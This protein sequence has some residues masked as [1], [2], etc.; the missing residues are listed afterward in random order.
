MPSKTAGGVQSMFAEV[1]ATYEL[2]NHVLTLGLDVLW[3]R[4]AARIAARAGGADW[5]DMCTGTGE[6]AVYLSRLAPKGTKIYAIDFSGP[7]MEKARRKPGAAGITFVEADIKALPFDDGSFDLITMSFATR[8]INLSRDTLVR[9]F[10]EYYRVLKPGG[11]FVN[12]ETSRPPSALVRRCFDLYVKLFVKQ[13][14]SRISGARTA[15]AYLAGTIPRFYN[16]EELAQ[17]MRE[18]GFDSVS[19]KRLMFGAAAIH[20]AIKR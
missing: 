19:F 2:V 20:Q 13:I 7:M 6:M 10:A 3:R 18:A 16:A 15:Y 4:R 12:Q 8:N 9:S 5:A 1:P 17:I 11:R 14:G